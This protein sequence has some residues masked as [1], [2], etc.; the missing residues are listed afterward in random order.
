M[1]A[2]SNAKNLP[3]AGLSVSRMPGHWL[4]ARAGKRVLRPGG[5]E[6]T[7]RMLAEL[8]IG[9]SDRI[10]EFAPGLGDTAA[11]LAEYDPFSYTGVDRDPAA[12]RQLRDR[13]AARDWMRFVQGSAEQTVEPSESATVVIAEAMLSMHSAE[14]KQ[15]IVAEAARLLAPGGRYGIHELC[16]LDAGRKAE[17]ERALS[18]EIHSGIRLLTPP[19]WKALL[20]GAGFSVRTEFFSPMHLLEPRRVLQDEGILR[21]LGI[22]LHLAGDAETRARVLSMRRVF[23]Q[24]ARELGA[25]CLIARKGTLL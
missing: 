16:L 1:D 23:T 4:L 14:V 11:R 15:Q 18:R 6:M 22:L 25:I 10:L 17:L 9:A 12:T 8:H 24:H 7:R 13:F 20:A 2:V 5:V 21:T 19:E 3:D